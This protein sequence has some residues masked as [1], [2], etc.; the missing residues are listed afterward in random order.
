MLLSPVTRANPLL[1]TKTSIDKPTTILLITGVSSSFPLILFLLIL[2]A[3]GR[4]RRGGISPLVATSLR[5][6]QNL[7]LAIVLALVLM[8]EFFS[9]LKA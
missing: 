6:F 2:F 5:A 3:N 8:L 4:T 7:L 1:A 9:L